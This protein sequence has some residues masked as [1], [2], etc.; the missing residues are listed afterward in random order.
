M[1]CLKVRF[2][3]HENEYCLVTNKNRKILKFA[4]NPKGIN[5]AQ[6]D[7]KYCLHQFSIIGNTFRDFVQTFKCNISVYQIST[8]Q[9]YYEISYL[10]ELEKL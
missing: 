8:Y 2:F 4:Q 10:E 1:I 9:T 3:D 7:K 6:K 5:I